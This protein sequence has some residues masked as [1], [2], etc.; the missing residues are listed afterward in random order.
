MRLDSLQARQRLIVRQKVTFAINRYLV[1]AANPDGSEGD[2]VAFAEQKRI[3]LKEQVAIYTDQTKS[4]LVCS[5]KAR[6]VLDLG[7]TYDVTAADGSP[8]GLFRKDFGASLLRSTW[9]VDQLGHPEVVGQE[10]NPIVAVVRRVWDFLPF[11]NAVPFAWPYHFDFTAADR[12]VLSVT[13]KIGLRDRYLVDLPAP[14][15][16]RRLAIAMTVALDALQSR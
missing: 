15:L 10:R 4:E 6:S 9:I 14:W 8:I 16:D 2:L 5:F 3:A 12:P 11:V 13:K 1:S 7:A